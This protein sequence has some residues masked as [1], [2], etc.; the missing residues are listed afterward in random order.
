MNQRKAYPLRRAVGVLSAVVLVWAL[1]PPLVNGIV[2][3]GVVASVI[4]GVFGLAWGFYTPSGVRQKG[5]RRALMWVIWITVGIMAAVGVVMSS[6][7]IAAAVKQP[8]DNGTVV[9]LGAR[10]YGERPSRMLRNRLDA[11]AIYLEDN[12]QAKCVVSGG[13]GKGE[14]YTEAYVMKKYLVERGIDAARIFEEG[15][16]TDTHENIAFSL[17]LIQQN[18]LDEHLVIA[19]QE[20]HQYRA[21]TLA[22]RAG[23]AEVS[24]ASCM[25]PP[26]LLLCYWVRECAAIARLWV[27]GY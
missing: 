10:I 21:A 17:E 8:A 9:V 18:G 7:M 11:A 20:F 2:N 3:V 1:L 4:A 5:W 15:R 23:V 19:T 16:S 26:H 12:P 22:R 14:Q 27:F 13:L 24:A 25:S 6:M